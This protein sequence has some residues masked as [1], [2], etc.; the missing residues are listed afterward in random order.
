MAKIAVFIDHDII[1]RH[2]LLNGFLQ[3]LEDRHH[4][5]FIFPKNHRRMKTDPKSLNLKDYRLI[6]I[7]EERAYLLRRLYQHHVLRNARRGLNKKFLYE[8]WEEVLGRRTFFK[9]WI[10]SFPIL[11]WFYK[12][13]TL[14]KV[15]GN[16]PLDQLL[17]KLKPNV[18]IHPTVLEGLFVTDLIEWGRENKVPTVYLMNSWDNPSTKA[19]TMGN[20]EWLVVWGEQSQKHANMHL[21]MNKDRIL[22][23]GAAQFEIYCSPPS[24]TPEE[25]KKKLGIEVNSKVILYAGSSKQVKEVQ[26]LIEL[27]K[28]IEER[29]LPPCYIVFRPHPWRGVVEGEVDFFSRSWKWVMMDPMMKEYYIESQKDPAKIFLPDIN[30]THI[31]LNTCDILISPVSTILL[32]AALHDKPI[33]AFLPEEDIDKNFFLRTMNNMIFMQEFFERID[34]GPVLTMDDLIQKTRDILMNLHFL[35]KNQ[36]R[37]KASYF[38]ASNPKSYI[39]QLDDL[40]HQL[41]SGGDH[42]VSS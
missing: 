9:T 37:E 38:V 2:F 16:L 17:K 14:K 22:T 27:E 25:F 10:N 15:G 23:F 26:H 30:Y 5:T 42:P 35:K 29:K 33:L 21:K 3:Q 40:I 31:I 32:E 8:F 39:E 6:E 1:I 41:T 18:I 13:K 36:I 28:A 12:R 11:Y 7:D 19:M 20:P 4:L 34:C 24:M